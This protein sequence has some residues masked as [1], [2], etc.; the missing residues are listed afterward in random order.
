VVEPFTLLIQNLRPPI[1]GPIAPVEKLIDRNSVLSAMLDGW[2]NTPYITVPVT[3]SG[4][5]AIVISCIAVQKL[6]TARILAIVLRVKTIF[7]FIECS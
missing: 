6:H 1:N 7:F 3:Q 2:L 5:W 4:T